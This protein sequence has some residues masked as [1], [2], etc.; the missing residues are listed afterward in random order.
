VGFRRPWIDGAVEQWKTSIG[1]GDNPGDVRVGLRRMLGGGDR[2]VDADWDAPVLCLSLNSGEQ[3]PRTGPQID[4]HAV[5]GELGRDLRGSRQ[6]RAMPD[7]SGE[8]S[9]PGGNRIG[10]VTRG[11]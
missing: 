10:I 5:F 7:T 2:Q 11:Q 4:D 1:V 6:D 3:F 9:R 8:K